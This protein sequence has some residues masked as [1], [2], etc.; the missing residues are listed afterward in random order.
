MVVEDENGV[1][2]DALPDERLVHL[3]LTML[4][5]ADL[6]KTHCLQYIDPYGDTT[7]N[8]LQKPALLREV[9]DLE[10]LCDSGETEQLKTVIAFLEKH[11]HGVHTYVKFY[12][13]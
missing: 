12:G 10:L 2:I 9:R 8:M 13:D 7:F 5:E 4:S 1:I 6:V 11:E 3:F